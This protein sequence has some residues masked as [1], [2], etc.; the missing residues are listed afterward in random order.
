[1]TKEQLERELLPLKWEELG[2]YSTMH[3]QLM[4]PLIHEGCLI[5]T[6]H[7]DASSPSAYFGHGYGWDFS[8]K[9]EHEG[10]GDIDVVLRSSSEGEFPELGII[11]MKKKANVHRIDHI[12]RHLNTKHLK[13]E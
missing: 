2:E 3:E 7:I 4:A 12:L 13:Y 1:M 6:Y 9:F 11:R 8:L 5:G 10:T